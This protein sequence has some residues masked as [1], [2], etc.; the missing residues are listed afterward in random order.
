MHDL[1]AWTI[2][3]GLPVLS[4]HVVV[5]EA[6]LALGNGLL[7]DR[8]GDCLRGHFDVEHSTLQLEPAGHA[9]SEQPA[10]DAP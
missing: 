7:L 9:E 4:A 2:T 1:H 6:V 10:C 3:S 8:L 5:D